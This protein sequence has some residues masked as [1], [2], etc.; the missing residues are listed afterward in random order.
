MQFQQLLCED[1]DSLRM[2][3]SQGSLEAD[4]HHIVGAVDRA[5]LVVKDAR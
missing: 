1:V 3:K 2:A 5:G 4:E